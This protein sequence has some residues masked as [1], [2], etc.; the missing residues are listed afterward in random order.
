MKKKIGPIFSILREVKNLT[1]KDVTS[2]EF[3][4]AQESKFERGETS[5]TI[6][7]FMI[8]LENSQIALDEFNDFFENYSLSEE[9]TFHEELREAHRLKDLSRIRK[10]LNYWEK[11]VKKNPDKKY[12]DLNCRATKIALALTSGVSPLN[13]D[14]V[15]LMNYLEDIKQWG[16]YELWLFSIC[17]HYLDDN[18]LEY[19]GT[20]IFK[21][22]HFY[23]NIH[24]NQQMVIR[25][26]LNLLNSWLYRKNLSNALIYIN[27][28]K[29]IGISIEF[30]E[31]AIS[32]R[33]LEGHY[34]FLLGDDD[35]KE[36][37]IDC[38]KD[39]EK[40]GYTQE[41]AELYQEIK[42]L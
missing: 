41:A 26:I 36:I 14:I 12:L 38:V 24:Q 17:Q 13:E 32:L 31:E 15:F 16:R 39:I 11:E 25:T 1:L 9:Y 4:I 33:Y 37:M 7:K 20:D 8:L 5:L 34:R 40:Y 27:R 42:D 21:K 23:K 19:Y 22:S 2:N 30:F 29:S 28:V 6:D 3:S 10:W 18:M 35:G